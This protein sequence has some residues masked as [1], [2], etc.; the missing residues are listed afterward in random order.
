M[1][2]KD[3]IITPK[4]LL[5][6]L[7][8]ISSINNIRVLIL[9]LDLYIEYFINAIY[10]KK[11]KNKIK[12]CDTCD[13][14]IETKFKDKVDKLSNIGLIKKEHKHDE[15]IK[16][17]YDL[18]CKLMHNLKPDIKSLE[19]LI[20]KHRPDIQEKFPSVSVYW[21][22]TDP[23]IKAQIMA[24][25][26]VTA[27]YQEYENI[28]GRHSDYTIRFLINPQATIVQMNLIKI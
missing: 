17:I 18:R 1:P 13:R 14:Y 8:R 23:W 6:D 7:K 20:E 3:C 21:G 15:V 19:N 27:L 26:A 28:C 2:K 12:K 4:E 16:I 9:Y 25:P 5:D 11:I 10:E 22:K 24:F